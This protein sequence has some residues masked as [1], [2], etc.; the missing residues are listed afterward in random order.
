MPYCL[1]SP[2]L[3]CTHASS[4]ARPD[5]RAGTWSRYLRFASPWPSHTTASNET[6]HPPTPRTRHM[7]ARRCA[8]MDLRGRDLALGRGGDPDR[9]M[10]FWI[11]RRDHPAARRS[12]GCR[13]RAR[14]RGRDRDLRPPHAA[15]AVQCARPYGRRDPPHERAVSGRRDHVVDWPRL[16]RLAPRALDNRAVP[17]YR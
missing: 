14:P 13:P 10:P 15:C 6:T 8:S 16:L 3:P 9:P 4:G 11:R 1:Q 2:A 7:A 12:R 17:I 5:R